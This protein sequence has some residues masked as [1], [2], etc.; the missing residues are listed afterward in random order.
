MPGA[1]LN[2][3]LASRGPG[4]AAADITA[5]S[6]FGSLPALNP[7]NLL[8][9]GGSNSWVAAGPEASL[10]LEWTGQKTISQLNLAAP[11]VGIAAQPTQVLIS[12]PGGTRDL[13][14]PQGGILHFAPLKTNQL[15]L[16]FP[17]VM[18]TTSYNPLVGRAPQLPVGLARLS[19]PALGGLSTGV[20][21]ARAPFTLSCGQGPP[22][23]MD[24]KTYPPRSPARWL[25]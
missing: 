15:T 4:P 3:L 18:A 12:S 21:G 1:Q 22:V 17:G 11:T 16:R 7:E 24:G 9:S 19:V 25:T 8:D 10:H 14:V 2:A 23:T 20:P 5:S 13:P 6:T